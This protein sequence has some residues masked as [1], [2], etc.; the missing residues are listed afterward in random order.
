MVATD[1]G[2]CRLKADDVNPGNGG[3]NPLCSAALRVDKVDENRAEWWKAT[4]SAGQAEPMA[5]RQMGFWGIE[6]CTLRGDFWEPLVIS[7]GAADRF[8]GP[9]W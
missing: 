9:S 2:G 1:C 7:K 8:G 5:V 4:K 6:P 3:R